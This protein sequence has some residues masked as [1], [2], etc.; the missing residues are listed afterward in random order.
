MNVTKAV[1]GKPAAII[2]LAESRNLLQV[3]KGS[4]QNETCQSSIL[5]DEL[6]LRLLENRDCVVLPVF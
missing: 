4:I 1:L 6:G 3:R 5:S 2:V